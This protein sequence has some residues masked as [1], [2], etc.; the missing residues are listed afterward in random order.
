MSE[1]DR[2]L[3]QL[4]PTRGNLPPNSMRSGIV[5]GGFSCGLIEVR[6]EIRAARKAKEPHEEKL[7][8]LYAVARGTEERAEAERSSRPTGR[9]LSEQ[10][11][12]GQGIPIAPLRRPRHQAPTGSHS[13]CLFSRTLNPARGTASRRNSCVANG[14]KDWAKLSNCATCGGRRKQ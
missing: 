14:T 8:Q 13:S 6:K 1:W 7:R 4:E 10:I 9:T 11:L 5:P 2:I 12:P 3:E